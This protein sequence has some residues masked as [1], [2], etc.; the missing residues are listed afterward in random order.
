[1][2]VEEGSDPTPDSGTELMLVSEDVHFF[3]SDRLHV[4]GNYA[5]RNPTNGTITQAVRF[6][7]NRFYYEN[8]GKFI[9]GNYCPYNMSFLRFNGTDIPYSDSGGDSLAIEFN[10]TLPPGA[11]GNITIRYG[12]YYGVQYDNRCELIYITTTGAAWNGTIDHARFFFNFDNT[13]MDG[14]PEGLDEY[15][16]GNSSTSGSIERFNW[17]PT[18]NVHVSWSTGATLIERI[19]YDTDYSITVGPILDDTG[20]PIRSAGVTLRNPYGNITLHGDNGSWGEKIF[21]DSDG[22]AN[23]TVDK[24]NLYAPVDIT[25]EKEGLRTMLRE[26]ITINGDVNL[27]KDEKMIPVR[28]EP[29]GTG[30]FFLTDGSM[31]LSS[32]LIMGAIAA[33]VIVIVIGLLVVLSI[34]KRKR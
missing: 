17:T 25:I 33:L 20:M 4:S 28:D 32:I 22:Y 11:E 14:S 6:P 26:N 23:F 24:Y 21:T 7:F 18:E 5:I 10:I 1:M 29:D 31:G 27:M 19:Y 12:T 2:S 8:M 30:G 13:Y 9:H 16:V 3:I 15:S 34:L